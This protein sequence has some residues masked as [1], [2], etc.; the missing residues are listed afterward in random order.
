MGK[1]ARVQVIGFT[2]LLAYLI[3]AAASYR[4]LIED[5]I[6]PALAVGVVAGLISLLRPRLALG[7]AGLPAALLLLIGAG[8]EGLTRGVVLSLGLALGLAL[9][10]A[11]VAGWL[12]DRFQQQEP[13]GTA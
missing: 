6:A 7:L 5:A 3:I 4:P 9:A 13:G 1:L 11:L 8:A 12:F 10:V 2:G